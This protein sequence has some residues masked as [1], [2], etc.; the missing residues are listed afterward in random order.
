[1][2]LTRESRPSAEDVFLVGAE[3]P[4]DD[5]EQVAFPEPGAPFEGAAVD[6]LSGA[7]GVDTGPE[8]RER[9]ARPH[10]LVRWLGVIGLALG[11]V[12]AAAIVFFGGGDESG[13]PAPAASEP[14]SA[15]LIEQRAREVRR[16]RSREDGPERLRE[17]RAREVRRDD[18]REEQRKREEARDDGQGSTPTPEPAPTPTAPAPSPVEPAP[19]VTTAPTPA[20]PAPAP[21]PSADSGGGSG[22]DDGGSCGPYDIGC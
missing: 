2:K 4:E 19:A 22:G 10:R 17:Q 18:A 3:L 1:V 21:E 12:T 15:Q 16:E 14:P 7:E 20:A 9:R 5:A 6:D 13:A 8:F 11:I